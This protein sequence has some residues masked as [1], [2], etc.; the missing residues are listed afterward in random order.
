MKVITSMLLNIHKEKNTRSHLEMSTLIVASFDLHT[1]MQFLWF[2]YNCN[3]YLCMLFPFGSQDGI[4]NFQ[5]YL[6]NILKVCVLWFQEL[7]SCVS[8]IQCS[9]NFERCYIRYDL[10]LSFVI[11]S[12]VSACLTNGAITVSLA[13]RGS[14]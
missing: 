14:I 1:A 4:M 13:Q 11:S 7:I 8:W 9:L 10:V 5:L 6:R 3:N 2:K 12:A